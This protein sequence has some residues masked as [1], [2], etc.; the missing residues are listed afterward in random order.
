MILSGRKRIVEVGAKEKALAF[1]RAF[2]IVRVVPYRL[3]WSHGTH[4]YQSTGILRIKPAED[5]ILLL[6]LCLTCRYTESFTRLYTVRRKVNQLSRR[7][8]YRF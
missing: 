8:I 1:S 7:M 4:H 3:K 2:E 6:R 5:R